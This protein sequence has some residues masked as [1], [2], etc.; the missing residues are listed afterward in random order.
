M[1]DIKKIL[2]PTDFSDTANKA[3]NHA[4]ML[5]KTFNAKLTLL[6]VI[7]P[8]FAPVSVSTGDI[9]VELSQI[10]EVFQKS[11]EEHVNKQ[12]Q[13]IAKS[14][15]MQSSGGCDTVY[16]ND[17]PPSATIAKYAKSN[18]ID[19]IVIGTH[20]R[21]G[22]SEW[23]FGSTTERLLRI[24]PCPVLTIGPGADKDVKEEVFDH[25]LF[26]FDLSE[27]SKH[28][29]RYACS[30]AEKYKAKLELLHVVEY[31]NLPDSYTVRGKE[32]FNTITDLEERIL[33]K[34]A[35]EVNSLYG[36]THPLNAEFVVQEGK[37][38]EQI[39]NFANE[40]KSKLIVIGNTGINE[41][42]GHRLGSTAENVMPRAK[43]PVLVVNSKIH[44]FIK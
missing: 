18:E 6:N 17:Y 29:L 10:A 24:A 34:M 22:L 30:F 41:T 33:D 2:V 43:C 3:A 32:I 26:P 13:E 1:I 28:A 11:Y 37:P 15:Q 20:G 21:T 44:D 40:I 8:N 4:A 25:I 42:H 7:E 36:G 16:L 19:L 38:F 5:A 14:E 27:A 23:F 31:R 9:T 35:E 39:I 12:L